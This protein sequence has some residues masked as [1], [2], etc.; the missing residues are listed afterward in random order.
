M[1]AP[2]DLAALGA[3]LGPDLLRRRLAMEHEQD[4]RHY[5]TRSDALRI[6]HLTSAGPLIR[7]VLALTGM[8]R[9]GRRNML[10]IRL[11]HNEV[12]LGQL[13]AAFDG[14]RLLH[15]SDLH[16]DLSAAHL[17]ALMARVRDIA[18][19]AC[20]LTGDYRFGT[21]GPSAPALAALAQLVPV[22]PR[23]VF[24]VLGNHDGLD[25]VHGLEAL[26]VRVLLNEAIGFERAGA[27]LYIA[28]IDDAH[29]FRTHEVLRAAAGVPAS[30][31]ALLLSH[32][33]QPYLEAA[34]AGFSLMLCGHTHGGQICLP[35]GF[36]LV[37]DCPAPR[38]LARGP[39]RHGALAGYTSA[40]CGCSIVD[41]RFHCPPEVTLHTLR[42]EP[43]RPPA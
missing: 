19:D 25:M 40:G 4:A 17:A 9:R 27:L 16:L 3:R 15:L 6:E 18:C 28:G 22:L 24:A 8:R 1:A 34:A 30:A 36:P 11:R 21:S 26:G 29:Y 31:C 38:A 33:P 13:P 12:R 7:A 23:P 32:T 41:A 2:A 42:C 5:R 37:T 10:D 14:C 20:V 35:G 43:A 39:W